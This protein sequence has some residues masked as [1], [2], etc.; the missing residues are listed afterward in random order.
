MQAEKRNKS[1]PTAAYVALIAAI[2]I[3]VS[4]ATVLNILYHTQLFWQG[5]D[6]IFSYQT[7]GSHDFV[8]VVFN[9][10]T[11]LGNTYFVVALLV[12]VFLVVYRKMSALAYITLA[13]SAAYGI[14]VLKQ[15]WQ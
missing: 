15:A 5:L 3:T 6:F 4:V 1:I 13:I 2:I 11:L 14:A 7:N 9:L 12:L 8:T 10:I